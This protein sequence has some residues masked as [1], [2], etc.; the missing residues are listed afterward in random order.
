MKWPFV[1][2]THVIVLE[3]EVILASDFLIFMAQC[4]D[5]LDKDNTLVGVSAFNEN[6]QLT[7]NFW[8]SWNDSFSCF[9]TPPPPANVGFHCGQGILAGR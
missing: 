2:Q 7:E 8:T 4:I 6:G 5:V 9:L 1:L 3:E